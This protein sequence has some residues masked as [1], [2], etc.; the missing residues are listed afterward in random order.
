MATWLSGRRERP[1][2]DSMTL[3]QHL[4]ELR[5]R[6]IISL[7]AL[8]ASAGVAAVF[9]PQMLSFLQHPYCHANPHDC[10]FYV[11]GPLDPLS[12]RIKMAIFGGLFIA[13]P[14]LLWELWR[15]ITPGLNKNEKR[16]AI[17]F[18]IASMVLFAGGCTIAYVVFPHALEFLKS[19]GGPSLKQ[20]L[21]PNQYLQLIL[22]MMVVFGLTFEFPVIL[23]ALQLV[24]VVTPSQL[25]HWWR[26]AIVGLTLVSAIFTP[27][28]DP[29]SML[30]LDVPLIVFYFASILIG[31]LLR[32]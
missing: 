1:A 23:V 3:A 7:I 32:R 20:I 18:V 19:V 11:Q 16:Y 21:S 5:R 2:P 25:L 4:G 15:F 24:R 6:L 31:K 22:L 9:Y 13:S 27:S 29:L 12:L 28:S 17:P 10:S 30:A 8:A 14:I 26:W